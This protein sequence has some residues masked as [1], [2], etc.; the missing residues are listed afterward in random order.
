[1]SVGREE[2]DAG[3]DFGIGGQPS[4]GP[5]V[6]HLHLKDEHE[7]PG[8]HPKQGDAE[9]GVDQAV[10]ISLHAGELQVEKITGENGGR[11]GGLQDHDP[12]DEVPVKDQGHGQKPRR[13]SIKSIRVL[14]F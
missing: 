9:C 3:N 2:D 7:E 12:F 10:D 5:I 14:S 1:M 11:R 8:R 6:N 4:K 13:L